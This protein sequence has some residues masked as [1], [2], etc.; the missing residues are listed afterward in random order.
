MNSHLMTTGSL[1]SKNQASW[2]YFGNSAKLS[3]L[4][5]PHSGRS[6]RIHTDCTAVV[7][8]QHLLKFVRSQ[9]A[10]RPAASSERRLRNP[11][12]FSGK[13]TAVDSWTGSTRTK[14]WIAPSGRT[15]C[16]QPERFHLEEEAQCRVYIYIYKVVRTRRSKSNYLCLCAYVLNGWLNV[17]RTWGSA[18]T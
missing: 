15:W 12:K 5:V 16:S 7:Q 11:D 1:H 4:Q 3:N 14:Q 10:E 9:T 17:P 13:L 18:V 8:R 2:T 6:K